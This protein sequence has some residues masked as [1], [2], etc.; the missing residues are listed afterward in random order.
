LVGVAAMNEKRLNART[1]R[2]SGSFK[3]IDELGVL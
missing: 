3:E 2:A 1:T